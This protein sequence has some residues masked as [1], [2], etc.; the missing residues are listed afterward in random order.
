MPNNFRFSFILFS[1]KLKS[2]DPSRI[3]TRMMSDYEGAKAVEVGE[4][5][6]YLGACYSGQGGALAA[7]IAILGYENTAMVGD[8]GRGP[9]KNR[10]TDA[11]NRGIKAFGMTNDQIDQAVP[12]VIDLIIEKHY[13]GDS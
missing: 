12:M 6:Y 8:P 11:V 4:A 13:S 2:Y 1:N 3:E 10:I 7:A 9:D 5:D